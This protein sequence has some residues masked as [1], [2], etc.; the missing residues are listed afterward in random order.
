MP[1]PSSLCYG[2]TCRAHRCSIV[3]WAARRGLRALPWLVW[4]MFDGKFF[5]PRPDF[6]FADIPQT[7][8]C[9]KPAVIRTGFVRTRLAFNPF[10]GR[11]QR[12]KPFRQRG[13][14]DG[15]SR[16]AADGGDMSGAG[17]IADK[18]PGLVNEGK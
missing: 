17:T 2:E 14:K 5:H 4:Q 9:W 3:F 13:T 16:H 8:R 7:M 12:R 18:N 6:F 11:M 10:G 15:E 1:L